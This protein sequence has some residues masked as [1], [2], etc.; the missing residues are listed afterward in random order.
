MWTGSPG[1]AYASTP[2]P[3]LQRGWGLMGSKTLLDD[4]DER[5]DSS[6]SQEKEAK[7]LLSFAFGRDRG[8]TLIEILVVLA[9]LGVALG[10]L[11]GRGPSRSRGLE[12]RAAAGAL[13]QALR[14]A[15]AQAIAGDRDVSV[16]IDPAR[17]LFAADQSPVRLVDRSIEMSVLPP[18]LPGPG[19]AK[20]IRFSGDGSSTGGAVLLG[21]G[22]RKL[23][24]SVEWL[25]GKVS[26]ADAR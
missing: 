21:N 10:V 7:R 2:P 26:V 25:T 5:K 24:I 16:A 22:R 17:H 18:A 11:I 3:V 9:I 4:E 14:G 20:V 15:R 1:F 6:F 13:A 8:F 19:G 12:T 23:K